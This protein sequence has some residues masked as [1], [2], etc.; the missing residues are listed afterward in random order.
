MQYWIN[1]GPLLYHWT[2]SYIYL[3]TEELSIEISLEK[4]IKITE[5]AGLKLERCELVSSLTFN[6]N[7]RSMM[8]QTYICTFFT[9]KKN[10]FS[11]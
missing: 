4:I 7:I 5:N 2:D 1:L 10:D 6:K 8:H 9:I 11:L 3:N